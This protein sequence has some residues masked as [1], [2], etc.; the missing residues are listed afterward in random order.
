M[1]LKSEKFQKLSETCSAC[2]NVRFLMLG[3]KSMAT[4]FSFSI[5][6]NLPNAT[7]LKNSSF[8]CRET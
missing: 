3:T 7:S 5:S 2:G 4:H 6:I 8:S 1:K